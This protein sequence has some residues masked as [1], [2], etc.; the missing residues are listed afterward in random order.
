[1][2]LAGFGFLTSK[3]VHFQSH[4]PPGKSMFPS[5]DSFWKRSRNIW[6]NTC[7]SDEHPPRNWISF[8]HGPSFFFS[9]PLWEDLTQWR[10]LCPSGASAPTPHPTPH[11]HPHPTAKPT[12]WLHLLEMYLQEGRERSWE[13]AWPSSWESPSLPHILPGSGPFPE[14]RELPGFDSCSN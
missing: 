1:M 14:L 8:G 6:P 4:L 10:V 5:P 12:L 9:L 2:L 7:L 11:P 13:W 3:A